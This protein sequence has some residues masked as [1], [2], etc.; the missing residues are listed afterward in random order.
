MAQE[1]YNVGAA[2]LKIVPYIVWLLCAQDTRLFFVPKKVFT[3]ME[4]LHTPIVGDPYA[5]HSTIEQ[6]G[7]N[8]VPQ[9]P[10]PG[11]TAS[12]S[13]P[14]TVTFKPVAECLAVELSLNILAT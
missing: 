1:I 13:I 8:S 11:I 14:K 2:Y 4:T 5:W 7:F 10:W 6:R 9:K 12:R 3:D